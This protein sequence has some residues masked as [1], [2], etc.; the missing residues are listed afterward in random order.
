MAA[1][2]ADRIALD[3]GERISI[4][5]D[6]LIDCHRGRRVCD[7]QL[8]QAARKDELAA[9]ASCTG[10]HLNNVICQLYH[11]PGVLH[12]QHIVMFFPEFAEHPADAFGVGGVQSRGR[13]VEDVGDVVEVASQI[14]NDLDAL[15]LAAG[16]GICLAGE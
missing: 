14:P 11:L 2:T 6:F 7:F 8:F 9:L 13:L 1:G 12:H 10:T 16:E 5:C 3:P 15:R 4:D